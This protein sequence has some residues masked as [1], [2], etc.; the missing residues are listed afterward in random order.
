MKS[1]LH[2]FLRYSLLFKGGHVTYLQG[3]VLCPHVST[4]ACAL[5]QV[6]YRCCSCCARLMHPPPSMASAA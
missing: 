5:V 6:R 4:L 3:S 2:T 1:T